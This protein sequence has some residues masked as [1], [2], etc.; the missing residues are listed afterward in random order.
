MY[1]YK[2]SK[3]FKH[4]QKLSVESLFTLEFAINFYT[5]ISVLYK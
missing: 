5:V 1:F 2:T 3:M 4:I